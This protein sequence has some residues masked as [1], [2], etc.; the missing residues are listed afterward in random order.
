MT[1]HNIHHPKADIYRIYLPR[2]NGGM[3][4]VEIELP[5]K[6]LTIDLFRNLSLS[7]DWMLR[8]ALNHHQ[9]KG[10]CSVVK[11]ARE[12]SGEINLDVESEFDGE[13]KNGENVRKLKRIAKKEKEGYRHY[14]QVKTVTWPILTSKPKS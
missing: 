2:S 11:E 5:Y 4:L 8:L 9:E 14:L 6:I 10:S 12:F 7:D 1:T 3:G 13:M